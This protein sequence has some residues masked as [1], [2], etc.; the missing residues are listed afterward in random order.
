MNNSGLI[1]I[2]CDDELT[3][4]I[5]SPAI[6]IVENYSKY[7]FKYFNNPVDEPVLALSMAVNNSKPIK[8]LEQ[9]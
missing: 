9:E 1:N 2:F 7:C 8:L 6:T 3:K 4:N 5:Y